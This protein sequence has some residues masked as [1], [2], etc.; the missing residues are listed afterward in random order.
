[1][2]LF[3]IGRPNTATHD[4]FKLP[5]L[6]HLAACQRRGVPIWDALLNK[7]SRK[8]PFLL[9]ALTDT[10]ATAHM[11]KSVGHHG[12]SGCQLLCEMPGHHKPGVGTYYPALLR[13]NSTRLP[14][15][16]AHPDIDVDLV[17]TPTVESYCSRLSLVM[18]SMTL[19][20]YKKQRKKT[21]IRGP[22]LFRT[23]EYNG[24]DD[25]ALADF[26]IL[27]DPDDFAAFGTAVAHAR[28]FIPTNVETRAPRNPA[29]KINSGYKASEYYTLIF[30]L[31]PGLFYG[32]LPDYLYKHFCQLVLAIR[33][34]HRRHKSHQELLEA[35]QNLKE[36]VVLFEHYY[37]QRK[38]NCLHFV[39]PCIHALLHIF[40]ELLRV[41][42]LAEV[43]QWTMERTIGNYERRIRLPADP[44]GNLNQEIIEQATTNALVAMDPSF[45]AP[46]TQN[47]W[48]SIDIGSRYVS[49]HPRGT[50]L[51]EPSVTVAFRAFCEAN[52]WTFER[53]TDINSPQV[54]W[55]ARLRLPNGQEARSLWKE[56]NW[57]IELVR[58]A[59]NV[60]ISLS[61][62]LRYAEVLYYFTVMQGNTRFTLAAVTLYSCPHPDILEKSLKMLKVCT[63]E[64]DVQIIDAKWI[65]EVVGMIPFRRAEISWDDKEEVNE[66]FILEKFYSNVVI[67]SVEDEESEEEY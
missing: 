7:S 38:I 44:Y 17:T 52:S 60:K 49:L 48:L 24:A 59:R 58:R 37:Y 53:Q 2:P 31:C 50:H 43:S 57:E 3:V 22:S 4:S 25:L 9:F 26:T 30:S 34:V 5:T 42:S 51:M 40:D 21:G 62:E 36:F 6:A 1:M 33:L 41:G 64:E 47:Q 29:E 66:Y 67:H 20:Q 55:F 11:S 12:C 8:Y 27:S 14:P 13:L 10:V 18:N 39:R 15:S 56:G 63:K 54:T 23:I 61:M 46:K 32:R 28:P 65:V 16:S 19:G 45:C 35:Q